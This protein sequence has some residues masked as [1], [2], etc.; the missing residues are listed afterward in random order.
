M[1]N[2]EERLKEIKDQYEAEG[3]HI[4]R[5]RINL[6]MQGKAARSLNR[7]ISIGEIAGV[8]HEEV[9]ATLVST[10]LLRAEFLCE[11]N[12]IPLENIV[13]SE[14]FKL[15]GYKPSDESEKLKGYKKLYELFSTLPKSGSE[16]Y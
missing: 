2:I 7:I 16:G 9:L 3:V 11:I 6:E 10:G 13:P 12:S 15:F 8:T 14:I 4:C 1:D 5:A